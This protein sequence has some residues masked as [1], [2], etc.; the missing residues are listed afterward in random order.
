[1]E[2]NVHEPPLCY[3]DGAMHVT[4]L[5]CRKPL[6]NIFYVSYVQDPLPFRD[7]FHSSFFFFCLSSHLLLFRTRMHP[8]GVTAWFP[9]WSCYRHTHTVLLLDVITLRV[10]QTLDDYIYSVLIR[11]LSCKILGIPCSCSATCSGLFVSLAFSSAVSVATSEPGLQAS[12]EYD[13][14][15]V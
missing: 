9:S 7:S 11:F 6:R 14:P 15:D 13:T 1:M 4:C 8:E 2:K 12:S 3:Q 10:I 5:L